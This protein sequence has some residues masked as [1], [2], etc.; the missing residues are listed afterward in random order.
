MD[1]CDVKAG[2]DYDVPGFIHAA[3]MCLYRVESLLTIYFG[4]P[5][6]DAMVNW[7]RLDRKPEAWKHVLKLTRCKIGVVV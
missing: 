5:E 6:L 1:E 4:I 7:Q 2:R 3:R